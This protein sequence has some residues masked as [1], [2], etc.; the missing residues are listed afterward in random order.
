MT[1]GNVKWMSSISAQTILRK[2][3]SQIFSDRLQEESPTVVCSTFSSWP[4]IFEIFCF[5]FLF[6]LHFS[7][8][9]ILLMGL[10]NGLATGQRLGVHE[11][12]MTSIIP[13]ESFRPVLPP[14][15]HTLSWSHQLLCY[16]HK[17]PV[18]FRGRFSLQSSSDHRVRHGSW[19]VLYW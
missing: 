12:D 3:R 19:M 4:Q 9:S 5:M 18:S 13:L 1:S 11:Q 14:F 7:I 17:Y 6:W 8:M 16:Y 10:L 2:L 15:C